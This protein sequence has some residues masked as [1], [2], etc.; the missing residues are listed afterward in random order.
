MTRLYILLGRAGD[1]ISLLP[2]LYADRQAGIDSGLMVAKEF[3]GILDGVSYLTPVIFEG[4]M[5]EI[6][7]AVDV[8]ANLC[9]DVRVAQLAGPR[10][11]VLKLAYE[12]IGLHE[13][14]AQHSSFEIEAWRL[15]G[16]DDE[17]PRQHPLV[18]DRRDDDREL[19]LIEKVFGDSDDRPVILCALD[20]KSSPFPF[21]KLVLKLLQ[22]QFEEWNVIDMA[23]IRAERIYDLLGVMQ[24]GGV[25]ALV[26]CDSAILHLAHACPKLPVV[27]LIQD[28]PTLFFGSAWRTNHIAHI[29]YGDFPERFDY[30]VSAINSLSEHSSRFSRSDDQ[31]MLIHVWSHYDIRDDNRSRS[32]KA[33]ALNWTNAYEEDF[34]ECPFEIGAIG[35][36]SVTV[37]KDIYRVPYLKDVIRHGVMLGR[38]DDLIV[39]TRSDT[40]LRNRLWK[41]LLSMSI[42]GYAF[43][44]SKDGTWRQPVADMF[45]FT[46]KFIREHHSELPDLLMG[47]DPY[48]PMV[49]MEFLKLHGGV[50]IP[51]AIYREQGQPFQVTR[52]AYREQNEKL[53][54]AFMSKHGLL[55]VVPRV[56]EQANVTI[57]GDKLFPYGYNPSILRHN[58]K[59]LMAY[60]AHENMDKG[61]SLAMAE[62]DS[63][64]KVVNNQ[65]FHK[66]NTISSQEDARLF[67][68]N[69]GLWFSHVE[70]DIRK[71]TCVM[72]Y[73]ELGS[74]YTP[75]SG[76]KPTYG[77]NDGTGLEKNWVFFEHHGNPCCIYSSVPDQNIFS[78]TKDSARGEWHS[79][80]PT[81]SYGEIRGGC[82]IPWDGKLLRFF[83][84]RLEN[85]VD[86]VYW[87]YYIGCLVMDSKPPFAVEQVC[88]KPLLMGS[89]TDGLT[90]EE[91][92]VCT[93][94]KANVVIPYGVVKDG[95][96]WLLSV[97]INDSACGI[98]RLGE[99]DLNL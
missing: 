30:M 90:Q 76:F 29:R 47:V 50:E 6:D 52:S 49:L 36:D 81:W 69:G 34:I 39:L 72:W 32:E 97:G 86:S 40:C 92:A 68:L 67:T 51:N 87:R 9:S 37:F 4:E 38:E 10:N 21:K 85:E 93:H 91:R 13:G 22:D 84:S 7:R 3:A 33:Q 75:T 61:S 80:S 11:E 8:A 62:L 53:A 12:K 24:W 71:Q 74:S 56:T 1:I 57:I 26:A 65:W 16:R 5:N 98:V 60:R 46:K 42:P 88:S 2:L 54:K 44:Q 96:D 31:P 41:E 82:V 83:H 43:R 99:K 45:C 27:A 35:R 14:D 48:W 58:G 89:E 95:D 79:K 28:K 64:L 25:K 55:K 94:W 17:W 78:L 19:A 66:S 63:D 15:A 59:L 18:F 23:D 73:G 70:S 20:G 77:A